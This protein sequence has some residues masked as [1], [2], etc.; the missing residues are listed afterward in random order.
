MVKYPPESKK[1]N[2]YP[3][4]VGNLWWI[5][6]S[7]NL[8]VLFLQHRP[9]VFHCFQS[10]AHSFAL[11]LYIYFFIYLTSCFPL[12][13]FHVIFFSLPLA[14]HGF[15]RKHILYPVSKQVRFMCTVTDG[16][17][18]GSTSSWDFWIPSHCFLKIWRGILSDWK[19]ENHFQLLWIWVMLPTPACCAGNV[20][21]RESFILLLAANSYFDPFVSP[22]R[23]SPCYI[24]SYFLFRQVPASSFLLLN[25]TTPNKQG[26]SNGW[27]LSPATHPTGMPLCIP[28]G[29]SLGS[30]GCAEP[31]QDPAWALVTLL[32]AWSNCTAVTGLTCN[33]KRGDVTTD[34]PSLTIHLS[35]FS[36]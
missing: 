9:N 2:K 1:K 32:E 8:H 28:E 36:T 27:F 24:P 11:E 17:G 22:P 4:C 23:H 5:Y 12:T 26:L 18:T 15:F 13:S 25:K 34:V 19:A 16:A 31:P 6:V 30:A 29:T 14:M 21:G 35:F 3:H 7:E 20:F 33:G 10:Q